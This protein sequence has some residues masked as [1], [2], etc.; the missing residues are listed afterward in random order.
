MAVYINSDSTQMIHA[1]QHFPSSLSIALRLVHNRMLHFSLS[2]TQT[3]IP[4]T[5]AA[6]TGNLL[7][8]KTIWPKADSIFYFCLYSHLYHGN[9]E[10]LN[11]K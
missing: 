6:P 7:L 5:V 2:A 8:F 4:Y 10:T 11:L 1:T 3:L 9:K